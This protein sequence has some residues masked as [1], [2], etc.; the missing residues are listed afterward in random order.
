MRNALAVL[1][2]ALSLAALAVTASGQVQ[3]PQVRLDGRVQWVAGQ[4]LMLTLDYGGGVDVD[5]RQV[6]MD[7]YRL[8]TQG[9]RIVV[10]GTVAE[11]NRRVYATTV[12]RDTRWSEAP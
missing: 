11:N 3:G 9:E 8:L 6:P 12:V 7:Q 4:K 10:Y 1:A 5:L 2:A